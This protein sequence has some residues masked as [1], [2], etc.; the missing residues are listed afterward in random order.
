M[1]T[2]TFVTGNAN[3]LREVVSI[4]SQNPNFT[5]TVGKFTI[6]NRSIDLEEIQGSIDAVTIHKAQ[7]AAEILKSPVL[8]EDTCLAFVSLGDL[9]GPYVKWFVKKLG[10]AG[11]VKLLA[12]FEDKSAKAITTFG[13]CEGPGHEVKLFQGV[14]EGQIVDPRGP[15][16]FGWDPIF[17]PSGSGK[18]YAELAKAEKNKISH[19]YKALAKLRQY[20]LDQ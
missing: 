9:P 10:L 2:I 14:T 7:Q 18:T 6:T 13:Y 8:V 5:P 3:K 17:E 20:L 19:R 12:G 15:L 16:D 11:M 1:A 4:L